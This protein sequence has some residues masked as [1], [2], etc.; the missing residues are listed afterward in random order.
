MNTSNLPFGSK[1]SMDGLELSDIRK[2][3]KGRWA[4]SDSEDLP[5]R[6]LDPATRR[7]I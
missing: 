1:I 3:Q 5:A 4:D 7:K 6:E 2:L